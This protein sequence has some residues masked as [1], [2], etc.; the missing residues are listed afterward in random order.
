MGLERIAAVLQGVHNNYDTDL[1]KTLIRAS[2][3]LLKVKAEGPQQASHRVI[4]DHLRSTSFLIADGVTPSNE[5]R[6]YVLRRIMRRAMRHA[7]L[8]GANEPVMFQLA[9]VLA[10]EMGGAFPE[11]NRALPVVEETLRGEE[12]R[13]QRTLGRGL[14]LLDEATDG[15]RKATTWPA[16]RRLNSMTPMASRSI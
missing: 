14:A 13:F 1:F 4:A 7:H 11:L 6:G 16:R 12:E 10:E 3:E 2:E 9:K 5:G 15:L 8:L